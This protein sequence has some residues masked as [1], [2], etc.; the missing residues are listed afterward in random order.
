MKRPN[1]NSHPL[2][3]DSYSAKTRN[4]IS[5]TIACLKM[6]TDCARAP[7]PQMS[8]YAQNLTKIDCMDIMQQVQNLFNNALDMEQNQVYELLTRIVG[9]HMRGG[10][11]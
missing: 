6:K 5:R 9:Y 4:L 11:E 8:S 7:G 1:A 3:A 2:T 10:A